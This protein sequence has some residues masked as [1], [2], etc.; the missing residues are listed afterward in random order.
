[1]KKQ[2]KFLIW[3]LYFVILSVAFELTDYFIEH[4]LLSDFYVFVIEFIF[5]GLGYVMALLEF[6]LKNIKTRRNK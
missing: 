1:M 4:N 5:L 6:R 3:F 2:H